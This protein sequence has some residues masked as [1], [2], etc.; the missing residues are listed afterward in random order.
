MNLYSRV[1]WSD[2]PSFWLRSLFLACFSEFLHSPLFEHIFLVFF[3]VMLRL[4]SQA[5]LGI[6]DMY[7]ET[8]ETS[9]NPCISVERRV[10]CGFN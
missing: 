7:V 9:E 8:A 2:F 6:S 5:Y 3:S 10:S 1:H 4:C